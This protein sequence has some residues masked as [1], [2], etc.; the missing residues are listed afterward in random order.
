MILAG[1][2]TYG[3]KHFL[4]ERIDVFLMNTFKQRAGFAFGVLYFGL[5]IGSNWYLDRLLS[6]NINHLV[7][8]KD[9]NGIVMTNII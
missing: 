6:K 9:Q 1:S 4:G 2:F 7:N 3:I 8:L 5:Y